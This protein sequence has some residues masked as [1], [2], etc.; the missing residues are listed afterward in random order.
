MYMY[1]SISKF[2]EYLISRTLWGFLWCSKSKAVF[3]HPS[4][5]QFESGEG[6]VLYVPRRLLLL[7]SVDYLRDNDQGEWQQK[8]RDVHQEKPLDELEIGCHSGTKLALNL[9]EMSRP[10]PDGVGHLCSVS[11]KPLPCLKYMGNLLK[12]PQ[13]WLKW[14][15]FAQRYSIIKDD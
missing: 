13:C 4:C 7:P 10:Q 2:A 9:L 6:F 3:T 5:E 11:L 15:I 8:H 14:N 1:C 12:M